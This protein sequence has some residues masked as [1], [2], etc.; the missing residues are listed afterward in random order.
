MA[1]LIIYHL[2]F[3]ILPLIV[4]KTLIRKKKGYFWFILLASSSATLDKILRSKINHIFEKT[5]ILFTVL[6]EQSTFF[7]IK[8]KV[9]Y[10]KGIYPNSYDL[11]SLFLL[12]P[13][14]KIYSP[15]LAYLRESIDALR[16]NEI[17]KRQEKLQ[18]VAL[19]LLVESFWL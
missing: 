3:Y 9:T 2:T 17:F 10:F 11:W 7:D 4:Q 6:K 14:S 19:G 8:H 1:T 13:Y 15:E 16:M 12:Y 5:T 18:S